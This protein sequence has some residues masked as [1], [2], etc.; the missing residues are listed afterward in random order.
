PVWDGYG[1]W[2]LPFSQYSRGGLL[3]P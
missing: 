1:D 2:N 3:Q